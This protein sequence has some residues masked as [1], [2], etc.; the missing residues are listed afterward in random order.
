MEA[1]GSELSVTGCVC[2]GILLNP[3]GKKVSGTFF[4][5]GFIL[6]LCLLLLSPLPRQNYNLIF[7]S[8]R[9]P[10]RTAFFMGPASNFASVCLSVA[11]VRIQ[12][13]S[14][15]VT[16]NSPLSVVL[17]STVILPAVI[18]SICPFEPLSFSANSSARSA[19]IGMAAP[20]EEFLPNGNSF[21]NLPSGTG[22]LA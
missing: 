6:W 16:R 10:A 22:G 17:K 19:A 11:K 14:E 4:Y 20:G 1:T 13:T 3:T 5:S 15:T 18:A 12:V 21:Q 7:R 8:T 2:L 9:A